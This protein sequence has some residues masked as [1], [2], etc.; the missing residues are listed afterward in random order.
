[1]ARNAN[2]TSVNASASSVG[3]FSAVDYATTRT[4]FNDST[5]VLKVKYGTGASATSFTVTLQPGDLFEFPRPT[6]DGVVEGIWTSATGAARMS[7]V[8][9]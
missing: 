8:T 7:E 9:G 4:I 2:V 3:L 5:A 6:Y 1:M